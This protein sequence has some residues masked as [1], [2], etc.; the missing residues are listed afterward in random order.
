MMEN[1]GQHTLKSGPAFTTTP[2]LQVLG[3]IGVVSS[4]F[5]IS[6]VDMAAIVF[7]NLEKVL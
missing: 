2:A 4:R 3:M 5:M 1:T 7:Q 6:V